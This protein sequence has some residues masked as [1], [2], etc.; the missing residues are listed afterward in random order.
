MRSERCCTT[1]SVFGFART[2]AQLAQVAWL[3]FT[4][5]LRCLERGGAA[6]RA[7]GV[8]KAYRGL[9]FG[10]CS[11]QSKLDAASE[12]RIKLLLGKYLLRSA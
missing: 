1:E 4:A 8:C 6:I 9:A 7:Y 12:L 11:A 10:F 2:D 5:L 3:A